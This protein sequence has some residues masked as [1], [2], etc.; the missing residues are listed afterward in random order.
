MASLRWPQRG[1]ANHCLSHPC[2]RDRFKSDVLSRPWHPS[3]G[4][5]PIRESGPS[6]GPHSRKTHTH[7][8]NSS[9]G[10]PVHCPPRHQPQTVASGTASS[11]FHSSGVP[12]P[13]D[14]TLWG[15]TGLRRDLAS[16]CFKGKRMRDLGGD[17]KHSVSTAFTSAWLKEDGSI[18]SPGVGR[19]GKRPEVGQR[20]QGCRLRGMRKSGGPMSSMVTIVNKAVWCTGMC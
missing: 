20:V 18:C 5:T 19:W 15:C 4:E 9:R 10:V 1:Q 12:Q 14:L 7:P 13:R 6:H 2:H 17:G 11:N 8:Y 3:L 16:L